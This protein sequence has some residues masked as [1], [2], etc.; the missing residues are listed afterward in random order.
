MDA[1]SSRKDAAAT[2]NFTEGIFS[3]GA[4]TWGTLAG[5]QGDRRTDRQTD[6]QTDERHRCVKPPATG[7]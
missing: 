4:N 3:W 5:S 6:G 1:A 2:V 7:T